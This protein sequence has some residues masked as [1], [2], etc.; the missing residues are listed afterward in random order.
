MTDTNING[1]KSLIMARISSDITT[2]QDTSDYEKTGFT[3]FP[4]VTVICS[5]NE[6]DYYSV[7][8]NQRN[9][10]FTIRIYEQ[11]ENVPDQG[12]LDTISDNAKQRAEG[13][14]GR[15]VSQIV[16]SFDEYYTLGGEADFVKATPSVWG[17]A[18]IGEGWCRTA[19]IKL[20]VIKS[21]LV[22]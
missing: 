22:M 2:V 16:D 20:N 15:V 21:Y 3:G 9:F 18:Q 5:G 6:N 1:L 14:I 19:E 4:A 12:T 7:A 17:Y 10:A 11:M 13:I 8:T